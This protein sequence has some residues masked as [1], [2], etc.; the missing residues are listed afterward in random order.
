MCLSDNFTM[1]TEVITLHYE[2]NSIGYLLFPEMIVETQ[3]TIKYPHMPFWQGLFNDN[4][5]K[6]IFQNLFAKII[7]KEKSTR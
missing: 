7:C 3:K 5:W 6:M 4:E 2:K 1:N